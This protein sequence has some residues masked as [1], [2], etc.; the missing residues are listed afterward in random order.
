MEIRLGGGRKTV[1]ARIDELTL[2][3]KKNAAFE[4]RLWLKGER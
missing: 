4:T 2:C 1:R 3:Y